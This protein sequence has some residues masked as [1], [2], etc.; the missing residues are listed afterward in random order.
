LREEALKGNGHLNGEHGQLSGVFVE[1]Q[2]RRSR[3]LP[4]F[5]ENISAPMLRWRV[6]MELGEGA[7]E[8]ELVGKSKLIADGFN[9]QIRAVEQLHGALHPQVV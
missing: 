2:S 6:A 9:G 5:L 7:G 3:E 1:S 8:I 4:S